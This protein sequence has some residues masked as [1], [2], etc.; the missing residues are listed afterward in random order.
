MY[1][2]HLPS[3]DSCD[4]SADLGLYYLRLFI[5]AEKYLLPELQAETYRRIVKYYGTYTFPRKYFIQELFENS[6][7]TKLHDYIVKLCAYNIVNDRERYYEE[8]WQGLLSCNGDFGVE[9]AKEMALRVNNPRYY[10][11]PFDDPDYDL[12]HESGRREKDREERDEQTLPESPQRKR[13]R[14]HEP[15]EE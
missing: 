10:W 12:F 14:R 7:P 6:A 11:H 4:E 1:S 13:R 3:E 2:N 15:S 5:V 8:H 9:T